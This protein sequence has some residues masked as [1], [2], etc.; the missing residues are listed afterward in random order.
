MYEDET[1]FGAK[2]SPRMKRFYGFLN[3]NGC[4][5]HSFSTDQNVEQNIGRLQKL[6]AKLENL[7][8]TGEFDESLV[9]AQGYK[10]FELT[11]L[12][13]DMQTIMQRRPSARVDAQNLSKKLKESKAT[14]HSA[15]NLSLD[16]SAASSG[17]S[18]NYVV[19]GTSEDFGGLEID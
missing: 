10:D 12:I 8:A 5:M 7:K 16:G 19:G 1:V 13:A 6:L 9:M 18:V 3:A 15:D 4:H 14:A 2:M 17:G 11:Q